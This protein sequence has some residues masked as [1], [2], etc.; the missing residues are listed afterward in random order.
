MAPRKCRATSPRQQIRE[1]LSSDGQIGAAMS[2]NGPTPEDLR[3]KMFEDRETPGS[4]RIEKMN[5]DG[6]YDAV[7]L[8]TNSK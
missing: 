4:W 8:A 1:A 7:E 5:E 3:A 2:N 6:G